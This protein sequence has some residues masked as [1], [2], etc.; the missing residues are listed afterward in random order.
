MIMRLHLALKRLVRGRTGSSAVEFVGMAPVIGVLLFASVDL[1]NVL[2][3][4]FRLNTAVAAG[5]NYVLSRTS[6]ISTATATSVAQTTATIVA[7]TT[8]SGFAVTIV[9]VN[10]GPTTTVTGGTPA[11]TSPSAQD[12]PIKQGRCYCPTSASTFGTNAACGA[13]CP[14]G[15]IAGRFVTIN[16]KRAYA[17]LLSSYGATQDGYITVSNVVQTE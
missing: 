16:A 7:N 14:G 13:P 3:T 2:Y 9:N 5:S 12:I 10:N 15:G 1:G 4:K 6:D 8:A 17:P 11:T